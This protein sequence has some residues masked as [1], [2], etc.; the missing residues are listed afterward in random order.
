MTDL[1]LP[2]GDGQMKASLPDSWSIQQIAEPTLRPAPQDWPDRLALAL[3]QPISGLPLDKLLAARA[4][5]RIVIVVED[6]TRHSPLE[7]VLHVVLR[8]IR[9]AKIRD[10]QI[11]ILFATG[12]HPPLTAK[13]A[14]EKLG[15]EALA[16]KWRCNPWHDKAA[17][18]TVGNIGKIPVAVDRGLAQADLRILISSVS[19]H[20]QAG[21]GGGY[22]M[23]VPGCAALDT[24]HALHNLSMDRTGQSLVGTEASVN[25]MRQNIDAAGLLV[26]AQGGKTFS[27]QYVLDGNDLPTALAAGDCLPAQQMLAKQCAV[28]CGVL[29]NTPADVLIANAFPRDFDLWQTFKCIA[30]T[31]WAA[32]KD[33]VIIC[34]SRCTALAN[35]CN[36]PPWPLGPKWTK[37]IVSLLGPTTITNLVTRLVPR[38][39]RDAAFFVSMAAQAYYRN[40][41]L[42]V[43]PELHKA[44]VKFPGLEMFASIEQA[45]VRTE[46]ILGAKPQRVIVFPLGGITFPVLPSMPKTLPDS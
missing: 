42:I 15:P 12:M 7:K 29:V 38:L 8:E 4:T 21:F 40:H 31:R 44:G 6:M 43:S 37:R 9:H 16:I 26:E 2:W 36:P 13:E 19:P 27:I 39:A 28:S 34:L 41:I 20:L 14:R 33:G 24:I 32:R 30:N 25:V 17:Y 35:N 46:M 3:S 5:G 23:V 22:K 11:E 10:E 45:V 18:Q 1:A